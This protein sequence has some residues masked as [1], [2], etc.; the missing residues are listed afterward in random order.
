MSQY[1]IKASCPLADV[2]RFAHH[3][4][5]LEPA[6]KLRD[7]SRARLDSRSELLLTFSRS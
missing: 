4:G 3:G 7:L 1:V 2:A 5:S 6:V